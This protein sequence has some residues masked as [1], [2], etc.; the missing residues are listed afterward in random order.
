MLGDSEICF[1]PEATRRPRRSHPAPG[2]LTT[3]SSWGAQNPQL[4]AKDSTSHCLQN[5]STWILPQ[6]GFAG[7]TL[8][9]SLGCKVLLEI[10]ACDRKREEAGLRHDAGLKEPQTTQQGVGSSAADPNG[11]AFMPALL[12]HQCRLPQDGCDLGQSGLPWTES[13]LEAVARQRPSAY[14]IPEARQQVPPGRG[15]WAGWLQV[16]HRPSTSYSKLLKYIANPS[17]TLP[18]TY[19]SPSSYLS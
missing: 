12:S 18:P 4:Q 11:P 2:L 3:T 14:C 15:S 7:N 5:I 17:L 1:L 10:K 9:W 13:N 8:R 16:C 6:G 19:S